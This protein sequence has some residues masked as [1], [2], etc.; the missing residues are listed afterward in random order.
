[1]NQASR[2][3]TRGALLPVPWT[4]TDNNGGVYSGSVA[5]R[6]GTY[7]TMLDCVTKPFVPGRTIVNTAMESTST[8]RA[9]TPPAGSQRHTTATSG[10][11]AY[12]GT[13]PWWGTYDT[14]FDRLLADTGINT[15]ALVQQ[16]ATRALSGVKRPEV[17][18]L[19]SIREAKETIR[20]LLN[21]VNG[22]LKFLS[23][24]A[25]SRKRRKA[26]T[27]VRGAASAVA[28][29][30]LSIIFGLLPFI[31]DIQGIL[32]ALQAIEPLPTRFTSRG[33][34]SAMGENS[35]TGDDVVYEGGGT[36]E[37]RAYTATVKRTATVRAYVL[38][39][40][41]VTLQDALGLSP[42]EIPRAAWQTMTLSFVVDWFVN[43]SDFL[44]ALTPVNDVTYLAS[45]Y[46]LTLVDSCLATGKYSLFPTF[47]PSGGW[48]GLWDGGVDSRV[49][50][51]KSRRPGSLHSHIGLTLKRDMHNDILDVYKITAGI[52]LIT[53]RLNGVIR[54]I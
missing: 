53:Q 39:E 4:Y 44:A 23:T 24:V 47:P 12:S 49:T 14:T 21:P 34:A 48:S 8:T 33:S 13:C 15:D 17:S 35:E 28:D 19:V 32:K 52:S 38:Y 42:Q 36:T 10:N 16:A 29:Q 51:A 45:G 11:T 50:I 27:R 1:M 26:I 30:H 7:D 41:K 2:F 20:S 25:P 22:A 5:Q 43:V 40:A 6:S 54:K 3:R 46:T 37:K 31:S 9:Y 18:G